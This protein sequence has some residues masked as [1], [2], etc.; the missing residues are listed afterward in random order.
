MA[1]S[2]DARRALSDAAEANAKLR[3]GSFDKEWPAD[4]APGSLLVTTDSAVAA[5]SL[6]LLAVSALARGDQRLLGATAVLLSER[7]AQV[8][9][10]PGREATAARLLSGMRGVIAVEPD[11]V[12]QFTA[13]PNDPHYVAGKQWAHALTGAETAWS[14]QTDASSVKVAVLDSGIDATHEELKPVVVKQVTLA[15]GS[16]VNRTVGTNNDGCGHGT[17]VAGV[18]GAKGNNEKG[19]AGVAWDA[20]VIDIAL[21]SSCVGPTDSTAIK[22]LKYAADQGARVA[23]MSFGAIERACPTAF[24]AAIDSA[25][26]KNVVLMAAS[27]N[28]EIGF[29][30]GEPSVPA[31]CSGV[32]SVGA[33]GKT[34]GHASYST[35]N[36]WV[37]IAAPGGDGSKELGVLTTKRGGGYEYVNGT[38]F[39]APY[40]AGV[41][42][43]A[44]TEQPGLTP[45]QVEALLEQTAKD[46]GPAGRDNTYGWG[47]VQAGAA[48][49]HLKDAKPI[50]SPGADP[51]FPVGD[52]SPP[53]RV[54]AGAE[55]TNVISQAVFVSRRLFS[56]GDAAH[57]V[58]ARSD[59][60]ADALAGSSLGYGYGPVLFTKNEGPLDDGTRAE[61]LRV[62]PSGGL[63]YL[64]GG[65][66]ALPASLEDELKA[67]GFSP[68]RLAG[69]AREETA[70]LTAVEVP[71]RLAALGATPPP[72]AILATRGNWPDAVAAGS[73]GAYFGIPILLTPADSLHPAT[74]H[75]LGKLQ[76]SLL[77][78]V[79]GTAV[80]SE[81]TLAAAAAAS[82]ASASATIRLAGPAR[83]A[84]AVAVAEEM[85]LLLSQTSQN[86]PALAVTGNLRHPAGYAHV[87]SASA[88]IGRHS[89][90]FAPVDHQ[91]DASAL[92]AIADAYLCALGS[93]EPE[94]VLAGGPDVVSEATGADIV[95]RLAGVGC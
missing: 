20:S 42:A 59:D 65:H 33:V 67:M 49:N 43:L 7:I 24:Q 54:S 58:L 4:A 8:R 71:A 91:N 70:A 94:A 76:P 35:T 32:I 81:D 52:I 57:A 1:D 46:K 18:I 2:D 14:V 38:S 74:A 68:K 10:A 34:A 80:I 45:D 83:D 60:Y 30:G 63:V 73:L 22:A 62:L 86:T 13:A 29:Y 21:T 87:L 11:R 19:I 41:A 66:A 5:R 85:E 47:L 39:A 92:T 75:R 64:M 40:V 28:S 93:S 79:G 77:Y 3:D 50:K 37:D 95:A 36:Q 89:G 16:V 31:S 51:N 44:L 53:I 9:V 17:G 56:D 27:G 90:V 84:T 61:L 48:L 82:G 55:H 88:I 69:A 15:S 25:R 26:A 72:V 12:R 78:V 6:A 23:T